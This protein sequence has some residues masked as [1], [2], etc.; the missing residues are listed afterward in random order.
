MSTKSSTA[1]QSTPVEQQLCQFVEGL[2]FRV[3][4]LGFML[5]IMSLAPIQQESH[6]TRPHHA[7]T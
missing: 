3:K 5:E 6:G 2:G 4:E 1:F 7:H